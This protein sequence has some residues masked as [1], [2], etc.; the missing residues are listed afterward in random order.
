MILNAGFSDI[1][2]LT[3]KMGPGQTNNFYFE[4]LH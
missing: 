3:D 4:A 2:I 1:K